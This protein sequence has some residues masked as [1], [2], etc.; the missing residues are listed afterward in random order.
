MRERKKNPLLIFIEHN[1]QNEIKMLWYILKL[2]NH[3]ERLYENKIF[4]S[5]YTSDIKHRGKEYLCLC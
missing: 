4:I 5:K 2:A 3:K 1:F